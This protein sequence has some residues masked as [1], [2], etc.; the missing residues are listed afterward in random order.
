MLLR[1]VSKC[2]PLSVRRAEEEASWR[3]TLALTARGRS[4]EKPKPVKLEGED[5]KKVEMVDANNFAWTAKPSM[6]E[7]NVPEGWARRFSA[8]Y[9]KFYYANDQTGQSVWTINEIC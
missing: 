7:E 2:Q 9:E 1:H 4:E 6:V 3:K 8:E 5:A